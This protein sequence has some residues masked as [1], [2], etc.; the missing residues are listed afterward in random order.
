[1]EDERLA[2]PW[3]IIHGEYSEYSCERHA[4]DFA[5]ENGIEETSPDSYSTSRE[6]YGIVSDVYALPSWDSGETDYP[7]SCTCGKYLDIRL[8][9]QG[10]DYMLCEEFPEWLYEAHGIVIR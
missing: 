3:I 9:R 2:A 6:G 10:V 8:T 5:K 1:M 7:V 4:R